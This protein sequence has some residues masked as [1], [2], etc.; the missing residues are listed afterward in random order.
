MIYQKCLA[1]K[2]KRLKI[3]ILLQSLPYSS[4]LRAAIT[5]KNTNAPSPSNMISPIPL[6]STKRP[7]SFNTTFS[8]LL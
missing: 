3:K 4:H 6:T 2:M 8:I 1:C 5:A 7:P